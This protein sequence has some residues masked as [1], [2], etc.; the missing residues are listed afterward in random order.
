[1]II[2]AEVLFRLMKCIYLRMDYLAC[3]RKVLSV[4]APDNLS[5]M[6]DNRSYRSLTGGTRL[7][8]FFQSFS[9]EIFMI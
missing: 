9:H 5:V 4:P 3:L 6:N 1:M 2:S 8:G 7:L